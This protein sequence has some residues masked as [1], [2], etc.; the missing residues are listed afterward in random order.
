MRAI[1]ADPDS[2]APRLV[3]A[4]WLDDQGRSER[5]EFIRVQCELAESAE[6]TPR[7][8]GLQAR[9]AE[10]LAVHQNVWAPAT[11]LSLSYGWRRGFVAT[12]HPCIRGVFN[13]E[14]SLNVFADFPL[15]EEIEIS[16][17]MSDDEFRHMPD[18]PNLRVFGFGGNVRLSLNSMHQIGRWRQLRGLRISQPFFADRFLPPLHRL[19]GLRQLS[20]SYTEVTDAGLIHL[21]P[22]GELET[23]DLTETGVT[24]AGL[25]TLSV[26][27][28]LKNLSLPNSIEF[29]PEELRAL[30]D[31][32]RIMDLSLDGF[33]ATWR[34]ENE[35]IPLLELTSLRRLT[36]NW[37]GEEIS[38]GF[39]ADFRRELSLESFLIEG[40]ERGIM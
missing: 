27:G 4:D 15:A 21:T 3:Y 39:A 36:L 30:A 16:F 22:F 14:D 11:R 17:C 31:S 25:A 7:R 35:L 23:L 28:N 24:R 2:D 33:Y 26:L 6:E 40:V 1:V 12:L 10:L 20:L 32:G 37:C 8:I 38:E 9:E 18:L 5:A 29:G 19:A 34:T 13:G